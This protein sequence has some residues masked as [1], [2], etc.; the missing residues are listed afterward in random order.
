MLMLST[1]LQRVTSV[2]AGV[3]KLI[4]GLSR[5]KAVCGIF[6]FGMLSGTFRCAS[7][8]RVPRILRYNWGVLT[9]VPAHVTMLSAVGR[10]GP[11][12][13]QGEMDKQRQFRAT[14][15]RSIVQL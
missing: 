13:T 7:F 9:A 12:G 2:S 15:F 10:I 11:V 8:Q 4:G 5:L 14:E 3:R 6:A 1:L